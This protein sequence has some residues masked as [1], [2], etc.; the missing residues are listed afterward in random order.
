MDKLKFK[1]LGILF[2]IIV[3]SFTMASCDTSK[4]NVGEE[5]STWETIKNAE[6]INPVTVKHGTTADKIIENKLPKE[7]TLT[8]DDGTKVTEKV[9]WQTPDNYDSKSPGT[10]KFKGKAKYEGVSYDDISVDVKVAEKAT[11]FYT[12]TINTNGEGSVI[13]SAGAHEY[14][15]GKEVNLEATPVDSS[16][17]VKWTGDISKTS[18]IITVTMNGDKN[19][20]AEFQKIHTNTLTINIDGAG[21]V[22]PSEGT[23][24]YEEGKEVN[25]EATP[26]NYWKFTKWNGDVNEPNNAKTKLTLDS[27]ISITAQ[28]DPVEPKEEWNFS[29]HSKYVNSLAVDN[30]GYVYS[31][32]SD[33]TIKKINSN[34]NE[35]WSFDGH[36]DNVRSVA[37]DSDGYVY[38]ASDDNTVK[39]IDNSGNEVWSFNAHSDDVKGVAVDNDGYVYSAS[40]DNTVKKIDNSGNEVWS[41]NGHSSSIYDVAVDSD[42]YVY[43][44]SN[45]EIVKK[46]DSTGNEVWSYNGDSGSIKRIAVDSDGYVYSVNTTSTGDDTVKKI[47]NSGNEVWSFD[48]HSSSISD[49]AVD[50]DGYVYSGSHDNTVKKIDSS[51][52]EI[53]SFDAHSSAVIAVAV[54]N[55]GYVY[56]AEGGLDTVKKIK[57]K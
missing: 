45:N 13:P 29:G 35:V 27:N 33:N 5:D 25:L 31:A 10:Y 44:G 16:E 18:S 7:I 14:E 23:H 8:L 11:T 12:L 38:S 40:D 32:S 24:E 30:D 50:N 57:Q 47:D 6:K 19:I 3:F 46:I 1:K 4:N 9:S 56:S 21:T 49:V 39:K 34:G 42:G 53:W 43:S 20:T 51:G 22:T 2:L 36:S 17:F 55:D 15:E 52:N 28:F 41:F 37:V 48:G 54:D 26:N